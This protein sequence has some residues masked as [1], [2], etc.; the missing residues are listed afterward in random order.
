VAGAVLA[1]DAAGVQ[2]TSFIFG[3]SLFGLNIV[4]LVVLFVFLDKGRILQ[5]SSARL[6]EDQLARLRAFNRRSDLSARVGS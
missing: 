1:L 4:L 6:R 5:P 2:R 3:L